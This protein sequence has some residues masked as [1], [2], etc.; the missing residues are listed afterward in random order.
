MRRQIGD[1]VVEFG[2]TDPAS[3]SRDL[4]QIGRRAW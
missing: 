2:D 1:S 4:G 3:K